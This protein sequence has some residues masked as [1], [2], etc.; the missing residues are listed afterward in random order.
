MAA[1]IQLTSTEIEA[2]K[3]QQKT[4]GGFQAL[5]KRLS[6]SIDDAGRLTLEQATAKRVVRYCEDYGPGG[7]EDAL[8]SLAMKCRAAFPGP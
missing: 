4:G 7:W 6:D 5:F 1:E 3:A 2:I 8:K